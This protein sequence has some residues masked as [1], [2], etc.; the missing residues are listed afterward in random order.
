MAI[1]TEATIEFRG[2]KG[3]NLR[4]PPNMIQDDELV[5]CNNF[6]IG[7][8]GELIKR[9]GFQQVHDGSDLGLVAT[10]PVG[11]FSTS[12]YS[13]I[14]V[15][16]GDFLYVTSDGETYE[17]IGEYNAQFGEQYVDKFYMVQPDGLLLEWDGDGAQLLDED[18]RFATSDVGLWVGKLNASVSRNATNPSEGTHA[19]RAAVSAAS[20]MQISTTEG[21]TSP[22]LV[23]AGQTIAF[24][25]KARPDTTTRTCELKVLFWDSAGVAL[26]SLSA[27]ASCANDVYTEVSGTGTA[28]AT[29]RY[30][31][32]NW[33]VDF[34]GAG[35]I[36]DFDEMSLRTAS[37]REVKGSPSGTFLSF[38]R[39]RMF[40]LNSD[41]EDVNENSTLTFSEINTFDDSGWVSDNTF[42]I[43]PGDGDF[44]TC[45]AVIH[46]TLLVFKGVTTWGLYVQGDPL[47]WI[48][49]NMNPEIGCISKYT[50][51]EIEGYLYFVGARGVY[52]TDGN[53][54]EDI[55]ANIQP[56]F[57]NRIVDLSNANID[58]AAWWEDKY[59]ILFNPTPATRRWLVYHLRSGGWTEWTFENISP[60]Y[61]LEI[62]LSSPEKGLWAGD[63]EVSGKVFRYGSDIRT[64]AGDQYECLLQTKYYDLGLPST[65]K[66]C[67]WLSFEAEGE[68]DIS[69]VHKVD[70]SDK[71]TRTQSTEDTVKAYKLAGA[72]YFRIWSNEVSF[73]SGAAFT[74]FGF[75]AYMHQKT[76][77]IS[78]PV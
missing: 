21:I 38:Y 18:S 33:E 37:A 3:L 11:L 44:L 32:L 12:D 57:E 62:N 60:A 30:A 39:D 27:S 50:P 42:L 28:P 2:F 9:V 7:R 26:S 23:Q 29:A 20:Q 5:R 76:Q 56:V 55:S 54:F 4:E 67:K 36:F 22:Q 8:A 70:G 16:A 64:D 13:Q 6:D 35:Q 31:A 1:T 69:W 52:K 17:L 59:I 43:S 40:V 66:R 77:Q 24:S 78:E 41:A 75:S 19:I 48:L 51:R 73:T 14:L 15:Q 71:F 47:N 53:L 45:T 63:L 61:F 68:A 58:S 72:E 65:M 49:R 25:G 74:F 34:P 10:R 46:D